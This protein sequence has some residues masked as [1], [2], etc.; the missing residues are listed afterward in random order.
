MIRSVSIFTPAD[1]QAGFGYVAEI[2]QLAGQAYG[3]FGPQ[4]KANV[5]AP[6]PQLAQPAPPVMRNWTRELIVGG[7]AVVALAL[8]L[9][10]KKRR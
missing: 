10:P 3:I 4:V 8:I 5:Y 1:H 6:V 9:T 2:A 7:F